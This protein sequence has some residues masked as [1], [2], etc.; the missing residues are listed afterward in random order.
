MLDFEPLRVFVQNFSCFSMLFIYRPSFHSIQI[1]YFSC[2]S[3][4]VPK[5]SNESNR[6]TDCT[7]ETTYAFALEGGLGERNQSKW[8]ADDAFKRIGVS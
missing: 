6:R 2:N 7:I 5:D 4:R 8:L 3:L 1:L